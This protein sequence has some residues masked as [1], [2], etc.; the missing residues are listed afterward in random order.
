MEKRRK[1]KT[2][3]D[4][5]AED[6]ACTRFPGRQR[7]DQNPPPGAQVLRAARTSVEQQSWGPQPALRAPTPPRGLRHPK[8]GFHW[9]PSRAPRQ[10][11]PDAGIEEQRGGQ[12]RWGR[13]PAGAGSILP[14]TGLG[15]P[16][17]GPGSDPSAWH[18]LLRQEE[19]WPCKREPTAWGSWLSPPVR[20]P[21][22]LALTYPS[23]P[24]GWCPAAPTLC[25]TAVNGRSAGRTALPGR[26]AARRSRGAPQAPAAPCRPL[27]RD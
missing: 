21:R 10:S 1:E 9:W 13:N 5:R 22:S 18:E 7:A 14:A 15:A 17:P 20:H 16:A 23:W 27:L 6:E 2:T 24:S 12:K 11:R 8:P 26:W 25:P 4:T 3:L 19:A